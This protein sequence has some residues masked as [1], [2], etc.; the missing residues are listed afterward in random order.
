MIRDLLQPRD[1]LSD[2][3]APTVVLIDE[4]DKAPRD[5]PN[6]LLESFEAMRFTVDELGL[7]IGTRD[8]AS[9]DAERRRSRPIV[10]ATTNAENNL[11]DAF[12]RRCVFH[13][14]A[15]PDEKRMKEIVSAH[16]HLVD[17][18][19]PGGAD[20]LADTAFAI[21]TEVA[22]RVKGSSRVPGTAEYI[23]LARAMHASPATAAGLRQA[24]AGTAGAVAPDLIKALLGV[25]VKT[26]DDLAKAMAVFPSIALAR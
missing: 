24:M 2:T 12:L 23:A 19:D 11:P 18:L 1:A 21:G 3:P 15:M 13:E 14:I 17:G 26:A 16:L 6:D 25:L 9:D 20:A 4:I 7:K 10:V 8:A 22:R 5:T